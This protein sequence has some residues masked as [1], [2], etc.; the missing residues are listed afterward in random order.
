[1]SFTDAPPF[2][3]ARLL[4][5]PRGG[6]VVALGI[7]YRSHGPDW[8]ELELGYD[9]RLVSDATSGILA[10]GPI[11]SLMDMAT[12]MAVW[13]RRG[14]FLP[15]VTLDL[16]LDYL[17]PARSGMAVIGRGECYRLTRRIA[18][19][20]GIAHDG[21][22]EDPVAHAAGTYMLLDAPQ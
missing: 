22:P 2:D 9:R 1:M 18:F 10:S 16:R 12:G 14:R 7:G 17:R 11:V 6:H 19:V 8:C 20:R 15:H 5:G 13:A 21:D 4:A 3:P